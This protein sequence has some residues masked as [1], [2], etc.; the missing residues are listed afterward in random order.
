MAG[1]P[2]RLGSRP[3]TRTA[4]NVPT[5]Q[6][7]IDAAAALP[8]MSVMD[9]R[10]VQVTYIAAAVFLVS[11]ILIGYV[12]QPT[13][14]KSGKTGFVTAQQWQASGGIGVIVS[15]F[16]AATARMKH[17]LAAAGICLF[18]QL[19]GPWGKLSIFSSLPMMGLSIWYVL[20]INKLMKA[21]APLRRAAS[22]AKRELR[23]GGKGRPVTGRGGARPTPPGRRRAVAAPSGPRAPTASK[24]YTPP[25]P[26]RRPA[27]T[28]E[29]ESTPAKRPLAE[30]L[31]DRKGTETSDT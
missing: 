15:L 22:D 2:P 31:L 21:Q 10:E 14:I 30:R 11:S 19:A 8:K 27:P 29:V 12:W 4:E 26:K 17:R 25:T 3:V 6:A 24:R 9:A 23:V 13:G 20:R 7:A 18:G 5:G 1:K 28:P 16:L